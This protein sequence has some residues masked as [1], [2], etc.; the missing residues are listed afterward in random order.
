[1]IVKR[2]RYAGVYSH[3]KNLEGSSLTIACRPS[4]DV[5]YVSNATPGV[6]ETVSDHVLVNIRV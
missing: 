2:V 3:E 4:C 5:L 6:C 1:M